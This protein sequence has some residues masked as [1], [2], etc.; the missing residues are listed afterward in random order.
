MFVRTEFLPSASGHSPRAMAG[1]NACPRCN[2][3]VF[4]AEKLIA[5]SKV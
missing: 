4:E 1:E 2:C 5:A 3:P